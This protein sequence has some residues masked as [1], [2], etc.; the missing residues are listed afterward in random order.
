MLIVEK[1]FNVEPMRVNE[2]LGV[3]VSNEV[4]VVADMMNIDFLLEQYDVEGVKHYCFSK[5][6]TSVFFFGNP[7]YTNTIKIITKIDNENNIFEQNVLPVDPVKLG[8]CASVYIEGCY[9]EEVDGVYQIDCMDSKLLED[10][11]FDA[12]PFSLYYMKHEDGRTWVEIPHYE[13]ADYFIRQGSP[14]NLSFD[15]NTK[16]NELV[17]TNIGCTPY[18]GNEC[19]VLTDEFLDGFTISTSYTREKLTVLDSSQD[20]VAYSVPQKFEP[21][22]DGSVLVNDNNRLDEYEYEPG[23]EVDCIVRF[24]ENYNEKDDEEFYEL[25]IIKEVENDD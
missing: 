1:I 3:Y 5:D 17:F 14:V 6:E 18:R 9:I 8:R 11:L 23:E 12:F 13:Y 7:G 25:D 21:Y 24:I 10:A 16:G 22:Y 20:F 19:F 2:T 15:V 4:Q